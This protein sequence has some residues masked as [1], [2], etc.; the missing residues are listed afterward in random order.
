MKA[1][2]K[3]GRL[4]LKEY[5]NARK[6]PDGARDDI[7]LLRVR[8]FSESDRNTFVVACSLFNLS[9]VRIHVFCHVPFYH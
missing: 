7:L 5:L 9:T 8:S 2:A 1:E 6:V 4:T 3:R